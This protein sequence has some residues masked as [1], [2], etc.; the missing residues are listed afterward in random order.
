MLG[1]KFGVINNVGKR[2]C[3]VVRFIGCV[4]FVKKVDEGGNIFVKKEVGILLSR[5]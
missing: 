5:R 4:F 1:K 3:L 2:V